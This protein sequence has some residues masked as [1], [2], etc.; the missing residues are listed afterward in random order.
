MYIDCARGVRTP[1]RH[2]PCV[3]EQVEGV[4]RGHQLLVGSDGYPQPLS[5]RGGRETL[6][7]DARQTHR[8]GTLANLC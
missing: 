3:S 5:L 6:P 4:G 7:R 1:E 8:R 2:P